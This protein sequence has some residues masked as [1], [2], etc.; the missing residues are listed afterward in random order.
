M[1]DKA[2]HKTIIGMLRQSERREED[3]LG[4][5]GV[6]DETENTNCRMRHG[7]KSLFQSGL[8]GTRGALRMGRESATQ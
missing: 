6:N 1:R 7:L 5:L 4:R 2:I 8:S 3:I